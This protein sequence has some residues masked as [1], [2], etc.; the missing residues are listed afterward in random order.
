MLALCAACARKKSLPS[1]SALTPVIFLQC[2]IQVRGPDVRKIF[3]TK[4]PLR[5]RG[6]PQ[7]EVASALLSGGTQHN[8]DIRKFRMVEEGA[9]VRFGYS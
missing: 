7:E 4:D 9:E 2:F 5:V 1:K 6:L 3:G 8:I